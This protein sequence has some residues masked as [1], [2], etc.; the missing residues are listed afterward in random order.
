ML[1]YING[2]YVLFNPLFE[3]PLPPVIPFPLY[4]GVWGATNMQEMKASKYPTKHNHPK[5][6]TVILKIMLL[7]Q[8]AKHPGKFFLLQYTEK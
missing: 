3:P 8:E 2:Y 5:H 1:Q 4:V 6:Y 7:A